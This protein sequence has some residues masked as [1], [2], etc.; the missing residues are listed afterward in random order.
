VTTPQQ[1][2]GI[3]DSGV[4]GLSIA[5]AVHDLL[6]NEDIVYFADTAHFPYGARTEDEVRALAAAA[7]GRLLAAGAKLIVVACNTASSA[8]LTALRGRYSTP[9]VGVVPGVKPATGATANR[10]VAVLATEATFQTRVFAELVAQ[11]ADGVE[12]TCQV[13]PDLVALVEQGVT[14]GEPALA[15]LHRYIDPLVAAGIDTLVLGCTH[16]AFLRDTIQQAAG[17]GVRVI[18]TAPAVA[19]QVQRVLEREGLRR[20]DQHDGAVTIT[21][22]GPLP[23]FLA[24]AGQLWPAG[25]CAPA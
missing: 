13:C 18:D 17:P 25:V 8:A 11:F 6:P 12:V 7:A 15:L 10:R 5:A 20:D 14:G 22:S 21:A 1:P 4:G 16:Y 23:A 24:V 2:I 19:Q 3:F 9:F